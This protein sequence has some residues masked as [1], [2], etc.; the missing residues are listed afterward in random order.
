MRAGQWVLLLWLVALAGLPATALTWLVLPAIVVLIGACASP[1]G[2]WEMRR[3]A[4]RYA[5]HLWRGLYLLSVLG[6]LIWLQL[7]LPPIATWADLSAYSADWVQLFLLVQLAVIGVL[8]PFWVGGTI[9]LLRATNAFDTLFTTQLSAAEMVLALVAP[10]VLLMFCVL[11]M[12]LPVLFAV[13]LGGGVTP[14]SIV[15]YTLG[16]FAIL[17]SVASLSVLCSALAP[18]STAAV[19]WAFACTAVLFTAPLLL[20]ADG[21]GIIHPYL[22]QRWTLAEWKAG[23]PW[24]RVEIEAVGQLIGG[25]LL[26]ATLSLVLTSLRLRWDGLP[27]WNHWPTV[28]FTVLTHRWLLHCLIAGGILAWVGLSTDVLEVPAWLPFVVAAGGW[29]LIVAAGMRTSDTIARLKMQNRFDD[30]LLSRLDDYEILRIYIQRALVQDRWLYAWFAGLSLGF[31]FL[32]L[33]ALLGAAFMVFAIAI[34]HFW[35]VI[36][37]MRCALRTTTAFGAQVR[38]LWVFLLAHF[39]PFVGFGACLMFVSP[40]GILLVGSIA[41]HAVKYSEHRFELLYASSIVMPFMLVPYFVLASVWYEALLTD[42][43]K[44][45]RVPYV[46]VN[47]F[48]TAPEVTEEP[49]LSEAQ[50]LWQ[51]AVDEKLPT[52]SVG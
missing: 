47:P 22:A 32:H 33:R 24:E 36:L 6:V 31:G 50:L 7:C 17:F 3:L 13:S 29:L 27:R 23:R 37:G 26:I 52:G 40:T 49:T 18:T 20:P 38:W 11:L 19:G 30:L 1:V 41:T 44:R 21:P 51:E 34:L 45:F 9:T 14:A 42:F 2:R 10:R 39:G 16:L 5:L 12:G 46:P 15:L 8:T 48:E 4:E 43:A 28:R 35:A 25:H